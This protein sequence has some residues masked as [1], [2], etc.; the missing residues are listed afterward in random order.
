MVKKILSVF[1]ILQIFFGAA[2]F[3]RGQPRPDPARR[4]GADDRANIGATVNNPPLSGDPNAESTQPAPEPDKITSEDERD[5]LEEVR[6][7]GRGD[8]PTIETQAE[9][10]DEAARAR[11]EGRESQR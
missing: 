1:T 2:L 6:P 4:P 5:I 3:A 11:E 7:P 8:V 9:E 10:D